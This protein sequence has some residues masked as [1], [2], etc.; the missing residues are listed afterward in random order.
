MQAL[1]WDDT[2]GAKAKAWSEKCAFNH[3]NGQNAVPGYFWVGENLAVGT[4]NT[5][6]ANDD[7]LKAQIKAGFDMWAG[8]AKDFTYPKACKGVCGHYTQ[9]VWAKTR[10]FGCGLAQCNGMGGWDVGNKLAYLLVCNY[11][12]GGNFNNEDPYA[13][14][15]ACGACTKDA[16]AGTTGT[17][18]AA[19]LC[20]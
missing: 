16:T 12:P 3:S 7:G 18:T 10:K 20:N 9:L 15:N 19:K 2:L 13:K 14:G 5:G 4:M 8:E 6:I 1:V 17:C 11:G